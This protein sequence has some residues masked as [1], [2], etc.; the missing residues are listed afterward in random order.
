MLGRLLERGKTSGRDDDNK[1]SIVKRFR[2]L[3]LL[4][5]GNLWPTGMKGHSRRLRCLWWITTERETRSS[6]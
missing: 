6:K 5:T 3:D 4:V 1:G 2:M